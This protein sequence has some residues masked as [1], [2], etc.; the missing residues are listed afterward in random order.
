VPIQIQY[1]RD[2]LASFRERWKVAEVFVFGSAV[3]KDVGPE[4]DV[5]VVLDFL[6]DARWTL[7]DQEA[8]RLELEAVFGRKADLLTLGGVK[9]MQNWLRREEILR[10]LERVDAA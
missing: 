6:A 1:D 9:A 5:D 8:M 10:S 2:R 4:S 3:R 7:W